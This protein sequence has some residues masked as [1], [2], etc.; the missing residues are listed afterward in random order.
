MFLDKP[1]R[2]EEEI[3][4]VDGQPSDFAYVR[5]I[6]V[7][8]PNRQRR[9]GRGRVPGR[10]VAY[11]TLSKEATGSHGMFDRR[12][13]YVAPHDP[14]D[15]SGHPIEGVDPASIQAGQASRVSDR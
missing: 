8:V 3:I 2:Y 11:A 14:Y 7:M 9:P 1:S 6:I 10:F 13:W 5:E 4:W 12:C 15:G